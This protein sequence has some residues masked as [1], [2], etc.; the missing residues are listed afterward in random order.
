M[1]CILHRRQCYS[2]CRTA[3][4]NSVLYSWSRNAP[5]VQVPNGKSHFHSSDSLF[6]FQLIF[7][8]RSVTG[9]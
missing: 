1:T 3:A 6:R 2:P 9:F 8:Q 4:A 5:A 7:T